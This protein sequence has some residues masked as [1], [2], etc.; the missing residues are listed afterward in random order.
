MGPEEEEGKGQKAPSASLI[1]TG[2]W[3]LVGFGEVLVRVPS[4]QS[5]RP[6]QA[7]SSRVV[8]LPPVQPVGPRPIAQ[9]G[10]EK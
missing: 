6:R 7:G 5:G 10:Q 4:F 3:Q 1:P 2:M 8:T 9:S